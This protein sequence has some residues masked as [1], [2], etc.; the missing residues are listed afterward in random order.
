M[1]HTDQTLRE[2]AIAL[3][4]S[5]CSTEVEFYSSAG[6]VEEGT[7]MRARTFPLAAVGSVKLFG[8]SPSPIVPL[9]L[10]PGQQTLVY[11]D[12]PH[13]SLTCPP[14]LSPQW[15]PWKRRVPAAPIWAGLTPPKKALP[16]PTQVPWQ[17][18]DP[19]EPQ[20]KFILTG[21]VVWMW[22]ALYPL[23]YPVYQQGDTSVTLHV[24]HVAFSFIKG[25]LV[26]L[27]TLPDNSKET[28]TW[29]SVLS[30]TIGK[31]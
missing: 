2:T 23:T 27:I 7:C 4:S 3:P 26:S 14:A 30:D 21:S 8:I 20:E 22:S 25:S 24:E 16:R 9:F 5:N 12:I 13:L 28:S 18:R 15:Q 19:R 29:L 17:S 1:S 31:V 10:L 11:L 6:L